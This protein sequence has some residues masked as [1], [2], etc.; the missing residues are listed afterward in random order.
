[1]IGCK[2]DDRIWRLYCN[3]NT[4]AGVVGNCSAGKG[5]RL[6]ASQGLKYL[7]NTGPTDSRKNTASR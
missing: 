1:M 4:W 2:S 3:G 7:I 5:E 6:I